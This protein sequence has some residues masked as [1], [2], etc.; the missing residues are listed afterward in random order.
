MRWG[1][2]RGLVGLAT[3]RNAAQRAPQKKTL[4]RGR[5]RCVRRAAAKRCD[6]SVPLSMLLSFG[7]DDF[8]PTLSLAHAHWSHIVPRRQEREREREKAATS[9]SR[10]RIL[11]APLFLSANRQ[12]PHT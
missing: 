2:G 3:L 10:M 11:H 12:S 9:L 8:Y 6:L 5:K 1:V 7:M 4:R